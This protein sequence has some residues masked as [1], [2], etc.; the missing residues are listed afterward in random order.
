M[1]LICYFLLPHIVIGILLGVGERLIVKAA[2]WFEW[3][4]PI[5]ALAGWIAMLVMG[6]QN[7]PGG[8]AITFVFFGCPALLFWGTGLGIGWSSATKKWHEPTSRPLI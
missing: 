5:V 7:N 6:A 8:Q 3:V 1:E 2:P 4:L